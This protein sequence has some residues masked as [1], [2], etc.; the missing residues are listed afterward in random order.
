MAGQ[1]T[2][3][4]NKLIFR[5]KRCCW[6]VWW[7][8]FE[9]FSSVGE[10]DFIYFL[11][12]QI[13][14]RVHSC[15]ACSWVFNPAMFHLFPP[16]VFS[17]SKGF[18]NPDSPSSLSNFCV[19]FGIFAASDGCFLFWCLVNTVSKPA[20][21]VNQPMQS[22]ANMAASM[23]ALWIVNKRHVSRAGG[24]NRIIL[25]IQ[26]NTGNAR[27]NLN[28]IILNIFWYR[29]MYFFFRALHFCLAHAAGIRM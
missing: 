1:D 11:L 20:V 23:R 18:L 5:H 28:I 9:I 19:P 29:N 27:R 4:G 8:L 21:Y 14:Q 22:M 2:A 16:L 7:N 17:H 26:W 12:L 15:T 6:V 10:N 24:I 3:W 25:S 13:W